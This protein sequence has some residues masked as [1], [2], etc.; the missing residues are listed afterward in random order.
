MSTFR[1]MPPAPG[2]SVHLGVWRL[3]VLI[4]CGLS[5]GERSTKLDQ[6]LRL[7]HALSDDHPTGAHESRLQAESPAM[8]EE[9]QQARR[10][11]GNILPDGSNVAPAQAEGPIRERCC[12]D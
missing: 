3:L 4:G 1:A 8:L 2:C 6:R 9:D 10:P 5:G 11:W 7:H 12:A